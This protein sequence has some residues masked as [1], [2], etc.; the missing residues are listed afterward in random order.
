M[1]TLQPEIPVGDPVKNF[2]AA[3]M[4]LVQSNQVGFIAHLFNITLKNGQVITATDGQ[5]DITASPTT[6][7]AS[8]YGRWQRGAT[9]SEA[10]FEPRSNDMQLTLLASESVLLPGTSIP[11]TQSVVA[12]LF[13]TAKVT[14][15]RAFMPKNGYGDVS[16][17]LE[18]FFFGQI[19][20]INGSDRSKIVFTVH[21][22][23]FILNQQMP[24]NMY[25]SACRHTLFDSNCTLLAS[26]FIA[27]N[28]VASGSTQSSIVCATALGTLPYA[29]GKITFTSGLNN[30]L[31]FSIK[32][33]SSNTLA[34]VVP[35]TFAIAT[36]DT[37]TILPG[38]DKTFPTCENVY[39]NKINFG[40]EPFT[41]CPETWL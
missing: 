40:G 38:C 3:L 11:M 16:R 31:T 41:P 9:T 17:G 7:Y 29:Q 35:T 20:A 13:D 1:G 6:Y 25:Q 12:R 18:T 27:S 14:I 34:L 22:P 30:G 15:Y 28:S 36:G 26:A 32:S 24:K 33:V 19:S 37:F 39:N 21:D 4:A 2:P 23:L 8:K 5:Y 10:K